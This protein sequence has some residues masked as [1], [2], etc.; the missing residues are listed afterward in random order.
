MAPPN[1]KAPVPFGQSNTTD[2][3]CYI[4]NSTYS[5]IIRHLSTCLV[6]DAAAKRSFNDGPLISKNTRTKPNTSRDQRTELI[7]SHGYHQFRPTLHRPINNWTTKSIMNAYMRWSQLRTMV[8]PPR[9]SFP[10]GMDS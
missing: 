3:I 4:K 6:T 2:T 9:R 5:Q 10:S 8:L 1:S 7:H